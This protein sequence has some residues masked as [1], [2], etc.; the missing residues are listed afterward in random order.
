MTERSED[1]P[2]DELWAQCCSMMKCP[3]DCGAI[4]HHCKAFEHKMICPLYE[5]E[6]EF[7]WMHKDKAQRK[8]AKQ[9]QSVAPKQFPDLLTGPTLCPE[10]V[11]PGRVV[12]PPPPPPPPLN[13]VMRFD[14]RLETVTRLQQKPRAMFTFL[15]GQDVR[16]DQ[17]ESH[18]RNVHSEI[19]GG[20]NNWLEARCPLASY[21]CS[22]SSRRLYPGSD[23]GA[24]VVF[25]QDLRSF[26]VR[27]ESSDLLPGPEVCLTLTDLPVE[28]LQLGKDF[29]NNQFE[30]M[31]HYI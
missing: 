23:P 21:G 9:T 10:T 1:Y 22:Y 5:E 24:R 26:G 4:Y 2:E 18:G 29:E 3:W 30:G 13:Q 14:L 20:L 11:R 15:C 16:R 31:L 25:S 27:P 17:W 19:H 8:A 7:D 28:L 6:G 12:P